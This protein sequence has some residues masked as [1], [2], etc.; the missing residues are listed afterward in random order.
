MSSVPKKTI[1]RYVT[2]AITECSDMQLNLKSESA[3]E[4]LSSRIV[5]E[6]EKH[7]SVAARPFLPINVEMTIDTED[8][9]DY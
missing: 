1:T 6:I 7:F 8:T 9:F 2:K 4:F 3:R 5:E